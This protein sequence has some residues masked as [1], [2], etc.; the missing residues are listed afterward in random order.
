MAA[1]NTGHSDGDRCKQRRGTENKDLETQPEDH[2]GNCADDEKSYH[3]SSVILIKERVP[4]YNWVVLHS[5]SFFS[6]ESNAAIPN[7]GDC[8][9]N[10]DE[11]P[12]ALPTQRMNEPAADALGK[13]RVRQI[14]ALGPHEG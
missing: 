5:V 11:L 9:G 6:L 13:H 14:E 3:G 12:K 1:C 8:P 10:F 2:S 4:R 7:L